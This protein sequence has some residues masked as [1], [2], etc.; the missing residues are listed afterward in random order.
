MQ[1]IVCVWCVENGS[2]ALLNHRWC[3]IMIMVVL[4][5]HM[6]WNWTCSNYLCEHV[7]CIVLRYDCE[8]CYVNWEKNKKL[9]RMYPFWQT[10]SALQ[11]IFYF[12]WHIVHHDGY[13]RLRV[14][15]DAAIDAWT[16]K[17]PMVLGLRDNIYLSLGQTC[18]II[19]YYEFYCIA[20]IYH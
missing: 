14:I 19:L 12:E 5:V 16:Y 20:H 17:S 2:K 6:L 10:Y 8:K 13:Y 7:I 15:T 9:K 11:G 4:I 1:L 18:N 3:C